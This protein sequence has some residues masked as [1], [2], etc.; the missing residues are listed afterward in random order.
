MKPR[1][2]TPSHSSGIRLHHA[3]GLAAI[4]L[5]GCSSGVSGVKN[6]GMQGTEPA[7]SGV[8]MEDLTEGHD[9]Y[10]ARCG[11][12]HNLP[13]PAAHSAEKWPHLVDWMKDR[14]HL[15]STQASKV[16]GW[17]L[18]ERARETK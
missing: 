15:D 6:P 8:G 1:I 7:Q 11:N 2:A 18:S 4:L 9:L 14:A 3:L 13:D 5:A 16:L 10:T 12:C 17:V